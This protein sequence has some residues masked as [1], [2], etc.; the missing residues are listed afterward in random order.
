MLQSNKLKDN[1]KKSTKG[2]IHFFE[3]T[4]AA[5][6]T[7]F[8]FAD[9]VAVVRMRPLEFD[10][11]LEDDLRLRRSVFEALRDLSRSRVS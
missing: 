11:A 1:S 10:S 6:T 4:F 2:N 3:P 8:T 5:I 7:F 9:E